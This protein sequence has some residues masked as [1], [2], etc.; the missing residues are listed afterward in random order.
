M[1][2]E[3]TMTFDHEEHQDDT[4][5]K[6]AQDRATLSTWL[7]KNPGEHR[8]SAVAEAVG[9]DLGYAGRM[10]KA[11]AEGGLIKL[12]S[13]GANKFYSWSEEPVPTAE[14]KRKYN[15]REQRAPVM[16]EVE[17]LIGTTLITMGR[18]PATGR[19]RITLEG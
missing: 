13:S 8:V 18:N 12:R 5:V 17:F 6:G 9:I 19:L 4:M 1:A 15:K 16:T 7:A 2:H 3:T 14:A 11:M 10:L